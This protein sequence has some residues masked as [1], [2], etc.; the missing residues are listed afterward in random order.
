MDDEGYTVA[1][2]VVKNG[3]QVR[4]KLTGLAAD[5]MLDALQGAAK[6]V[7]AGAPVV[8]SELDKTTPEE[9][10]EALAGLGLEPTAE[11]FAAEGDAEQQPS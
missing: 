6:A 9:A 2:Y 5:K 10:T 8:F 11:V 7:A 4:V 1:A 3:G